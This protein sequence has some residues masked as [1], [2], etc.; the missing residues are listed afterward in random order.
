MVN[1]TAIVTR[2]YNIHGEYLQLLLRNEQFNAHTIFEAIFLPHLDRN[3]NSRPVLQNLR[4]WR[5]CGQQSDRVYLKNYYAIVVVDM[6]RYKKIVLLDKPFE[7][8]LKYIKLICNQNV[9]PADMVHGRTGQLY[10]GAV[11]LASSA[12]QQQQ[13]IVAD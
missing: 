3:A 2:V 11:A 4:L 7:T 1:T 10:R 5:Y 8:R 12:K 13:P 9:M 6:L